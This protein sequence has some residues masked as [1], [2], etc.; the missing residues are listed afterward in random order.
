MLFFKLMTMGL[1]LCH[2][3]RKFLVHKWNSGEQFRATLALLLFST[4][5]EFAILKKQVS[6][7]KRL[8]KEMDL[9]LTKMFK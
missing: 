2:I 7:R 6:F 9:L 3:D 4:L 1:H 8:H 5:S